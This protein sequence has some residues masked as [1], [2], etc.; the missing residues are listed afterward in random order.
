MNWTVIDPKVKLAVGIVITTAIGISS[1]SLVLKGA[2][3][4]NW[5]P[6]ITAWSGIIA[7]VGS[8]IQTSLQG[9]GVTTA[10]RISAAASLPDVK[11]VVTTET[12]ANTGALAANDKVVSK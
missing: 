2:F 12:V 4:D 11:Q 8:A 1:G 9:F 10:S 7:F 5:I 6:Y 3:P